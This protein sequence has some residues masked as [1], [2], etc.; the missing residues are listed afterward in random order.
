[1]IE[2]SIAADPLHGLRDV[3]VRAVI[4]V[5][6]ARPEAASALIF[7]S[8]GPAPLNTAP[9]I[10]AVRTARVGQP[11]QDLPPDHFLLSL[12]VAQANAIR[13]V[14][15]SGSLEEYDSVDLSGTTVRLRERITYSFYANDSLALGRGLV[16]KQG[17]IP[18]VIYR[19]LDDFEA[20]EPDPGTPDGPQGLFV[21]VPVRAGGGSG[22][23]WIV[24]R[25]S[26]GAASW[27]SIPY[28]AADERGCGGASP[29]GGPTPVD[30]RCPQLQFG[31]F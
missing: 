27:V 4:H 26:R 6:G 23:V 11:L 14:P 21:A 13:P 3:R 5:E 29:G 28:V 17:A 24:A 25:D 9:V 2:R 10:A 30:S 19:G 1:L 15:R 31:C 16:L 18:V 22:T 20:D 12:S 7:F 8:S